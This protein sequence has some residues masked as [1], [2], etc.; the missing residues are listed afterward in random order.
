MEQFGI[1][2]VAFKTSLEK[3]SDMKTMYVKFLN[4][5]IIVEMPGSCVIELPNHSIVELYTEI[6]DTPAY[7]FENNT[8]VIGYR[9]EN[10]NLM[11]DLMKSEN[12]KL[13][14]PI[15]HAGECY[16]YFHFLNPCHQVCMINEIHKH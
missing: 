13:L 4:G 9:T 1:Q 8:T 7:L 16:S 2:S 6:S 3:L 12:I 10:L 5:K 15:Q 14:S 11:Y